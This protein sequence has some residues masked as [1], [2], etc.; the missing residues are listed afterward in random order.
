MYCRLHAGPAPP[1]ADEDLRRPA[2]LG[3]VAAFL[4]KLGSAAAAGSVKAR[5][6]SVW[7]VTA[8]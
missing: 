3:A 5:V 7:P 2:T 1:H 8:L 4:S 6:S